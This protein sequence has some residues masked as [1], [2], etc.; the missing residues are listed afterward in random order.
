VRTVVAIV[1]FSA[2][3]A[4]GPGGDDVFDASRYDAHTAPPDADICLVP[5]DFVAPALANQAA[6][7]V[8]ADHAVPEA[9][10]FD[11]DLDADARPDILQLELTKGYGAFLDNIVPGTYVLAGD[12]LNYS[13]CG[14]CA[15]VFVDLDTTSGMPRKQQYF[16]TAG[17]FTITAID[18]NVTGTFSDL[19]LV[20]ITLS[21]DGTYRS[22]PVPDG[23]TTAVSS[24][25]F[26]IA[27]E[28]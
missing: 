14:L 21:T 2:L 12:D 22:T 20:E 18:P 25:S 28:Y 6:T 17:S 23:C 5:T 19:Q 8:G 27:V 4:C 11:G 13:T 16:A 9:I 1:C 7:G 24:G 3:A 26:D 15:R 10:V